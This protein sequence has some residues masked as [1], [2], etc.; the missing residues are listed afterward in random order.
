MAKILIIDDDELICESLS[1]LVGRMGHEAA[2]A[3]TL[4]DGLDQV[5][6]GE[7]DVV[8]LDV[9][10]PDG[11]GLGAIPEIRESSARPEVIII[12]GEGDPEGAEL[13]IKSGAWDYVEKPA[14]MTMMT[15]PLVRALQYRQEKAAAKPL[16]SLKREGIIGRSG[17]IS[18]CLDLVAQAAQGV[19]N[20]LI[21]GETGTGKELFA[22]AIH[23]NSNRADKNFVVVDCA[24]LPGTLVESVLFGHEK[25][26]FTGA[27][28]SKTGLVRQAHKGTLFLDEV[29]E[30]PMPVQKAFLR[31]LQEHRFRPV[32][33]ESEMRSDFRLVAATNRDLEAMS[34]NGLFRNDLL[35]RLRGM[36]INLP[37][38][39]ERGEDI[40]VLALHHVA[41]LCDR[42]GIA[43][44]GFSPEFFEALM[45]YDWPGNVR[46][47][48]N[49]LEAVLSATLQEHT[50]FPRHL[51]THIRVHV[52]RSS[53]THEPVPSKLPGNPNKPV[54]TLTT[55]KA[56]R[57][58]A[59]EEAEKQY[60]ENLIPLARQDLKKACRVSGLSRSRFY[61]L[62]KKHQLS[63]SQ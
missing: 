9:R 50:L 47:L 1:S 7:Y 41:S 16:V 45:A 33:S 44:K 53:V 59:A 27:D 58:A 31:V 15:L 38:L 62:I 60:L 56:F 10:L 18:A 4:G 34:S 42:Y 3:L 48:M 46:E 52:A 25:G 22:R 29:G 49:S 23:D 37:P 55:L 61:E 19:Q 28:R 54:D 43:T 51:P 36:S 21:N 11:N 63:I 8:F 39:K 6:Q 35:F 57:A 13:A 32:G 40:K 30:L 26:A 20:V 17:Q 14:S 24:A 12:T 2:W 5:S